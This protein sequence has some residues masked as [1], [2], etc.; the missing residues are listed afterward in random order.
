MSGEIGVASRNFWASMGDPGC[1]WG[2][3]RVVDQCARVEHLRFDG[4][5]MLSGDIHASIF[6]LRCLTR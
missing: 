4:A 5:R 2:V 6:R 1:Y 3:R